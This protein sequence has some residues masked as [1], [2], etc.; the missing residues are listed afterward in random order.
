MRSLASLLC[1]S[2]HPQLVPYTVFQSADGYLV[3]GAGVRT[4]S[5]RWRVRVELPHRLRDMAHEVA[6]R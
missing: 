3:I 6:Q 5:R 1:S 2:G 4:A